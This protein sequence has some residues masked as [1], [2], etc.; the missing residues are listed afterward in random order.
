[1][2]KELYGEKIRKINRNSV[3]VYRL[4]SRVFYFAKIISIEY[5]N[6]S[7]LFAAF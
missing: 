2:L 6:A 7:E 4:R 1:V 5:F 3:F